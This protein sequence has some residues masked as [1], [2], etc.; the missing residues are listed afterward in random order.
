MSTFTLSDEVAYIFEGL[1]R[2]I[3]LQEQLRMR[4]SPVAGCS[5]K[6]SALHAFL[7]F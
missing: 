6:V 3:N 5:I 2:L 4:L 1:L 7:Y